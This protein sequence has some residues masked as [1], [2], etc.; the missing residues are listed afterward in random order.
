MGSIG[1]FALSIMTAEWVVNGGSLLGMPRQLGLVLA[2]CSLIFVQLLT[3]YGLKRRLRALGQGFQWVGLIVVQ[4]VLF[5]AA[6]IAHRRTYS[7][8]LAILYIA[9]QALFLFD[10]RSKARS[11]EG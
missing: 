1:A 2:W 9:S 7:F 6:L 11:E 8:L 4:W 10:L 5:D 3:L